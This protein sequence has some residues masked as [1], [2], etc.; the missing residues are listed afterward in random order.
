MLWR[1]RR[2]ARLARETTQWALRHPRRIVVLSL[3]IVMTVIIPEGIKMG[4]AVPLLNV[5]RN[6]DF[7]T[8]L[9]HMDDFGIKYIVVLAP[10]PH[11]KDSIAAD[12]RPHY[13]NRKF[14]A[15]PFYL[16]MW[17]NDGWSSGDLLYIE[18]KF[19]VVVERAC[20]HYG[21][22]VFGGRIAA[23]N[24]HYGEKHSVNGIAFGPYDYSKNR[25]FNG[26]KGA[27]RQQQLT[28]AGPEQLAS[29]VPQCECKESDDKTSERGK[30][31]VVFVDNSDRANRLRTDLAEDDDD[32]G[33][34][35]AFFGAVG[36]GLG[37]YTLLKLMDR[38]I[39]KCD[40]NR[41]KNQKC[42]NQISSK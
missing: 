34:L 9:N 4:L 2:K 39:F 35:I 42:S 7:V 20:G 17:P 36:A 29:G 23:I 19:G 3:S 21:P 26:D 13:V 25:V 11:E 8:K 40:E 27:L 12:D 18:D 1:K 32:A 22:H 38:K 24:P 28:F 30:K 41:S 31:S 14:E 33:F 6:G 5:P 16:G 37:S 10:A 15:T